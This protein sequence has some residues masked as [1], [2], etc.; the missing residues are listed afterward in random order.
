MNAVIYTDGGFRYANIPDGAFASDVN[1]STLH[2]GLS[3]R[4]W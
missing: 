3:W 2:I 4:L 1:L